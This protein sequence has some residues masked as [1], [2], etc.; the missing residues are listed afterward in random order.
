[1]LNKLF[2]EHAPEILESTVIY[3]R[4]QKG[5]PLILWEFRNASMLSNGRI[6]QNV[7]KE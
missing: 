5:C 4:R 7:A 3:D 1:M 2:F 6:L